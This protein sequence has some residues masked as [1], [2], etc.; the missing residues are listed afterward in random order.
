M[1]FILNIS[2]I[3]PDSCSVSFGWR[4]R[5]LLHDKH[6]DTFKQAMILHGRG[7]NILFYDSPFEAKTLGDV[8]R[9]YDRAANYLFNKFKSALRPSSFDCNILV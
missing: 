7:C 6:W 3:R 9:M 4:T 8:G 2:I 1:L 5:T